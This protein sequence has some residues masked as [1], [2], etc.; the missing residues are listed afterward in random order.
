MVGNTRALLDRMRRS[1]L[2]H[3]IIIPLAIDGNMRGAAKQ[4]RFD[5]VV[6]DIGVNAR[7]LK[8]VDDRNGL[9]TKH[10]PGFPI[11]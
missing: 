10:R 1:H 9:A 5:E 2:F 6:V 4:D 7:L 11:G 8:R 3:E